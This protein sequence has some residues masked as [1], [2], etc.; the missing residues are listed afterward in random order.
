MYNIGV[1]DCESFIIKP[2]CVQY[3][4]CKQTLY[5]FLFIF[6]YFCLCSIFKAN[7]LLVYIFFGSP[8]YPDSSDE[9]SILSDENSPSTALLNECD[10]SVFD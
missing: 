7:V 8:V 10:V 4:I 3:T 1:S 9:D 6:A 2:S 5:L